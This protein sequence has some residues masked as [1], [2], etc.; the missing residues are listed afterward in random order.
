MHDGL[1]M[2][3]Y[4][5]VLV[6]GLAMTAAFAGARHLADEV[7]MATGQNSAERE[8]KRRGAKGRRRLFLS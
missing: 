1:W 4:L 5:F 2:G 6:G 7:L 8:R 3:G